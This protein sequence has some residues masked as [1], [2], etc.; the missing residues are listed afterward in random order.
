MANEQNLIK[1]SERTP[2]ERRENSSLTENEQRRLHSLKLERSLRKW[3]IS[4]YHLSSRKGT[5][6]LPYL[7]LQHAFKHEQV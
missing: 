1:N 4:P 7:H 6:N 5:N 2:S 3:G